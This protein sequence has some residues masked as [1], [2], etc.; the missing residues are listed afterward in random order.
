MERI[1]LSHLLLLIVCTVISTTVSAQIS[2]RQNINL[3]EGWTIRPAYDVNRQ[4]PK[5]KITLPHIWNTSDGFDKINYSRESMIY[6]RRLNWFEDMTQKRLFL[7][8]DGVNSTCTVLVNGKV[9]GKHVGGYTAFCFEITDYVEEGEDALI[10]VYVSNV[11][12]LDVIPLSG[13]FNIYGGI[14]RPVHLLVTEKNCISPLDYA[15][16]GVYVKPVKVS[17][18]KA[19]FYVE[20]V[21]S[22]TEEKH[23]LKLG[24]TLIDHNQKEVESKI[25]EIKDNGS[26][27]VSQLLEIKNPI[28]WNGK[29]NPYCYQLKVALLK[30]N[31]I[32]DEVTETTG[33]RYFS[34]DPENGFSL[35]GKYLDLYGF[36]IHQDIAERGSAYLPCD[37][38]NSMELVKESGATVLRLTHY[39]HG[40]MMYDLADKN[41]IVLWTEIPF[42]GPG[43]YTGP[44]YVKDE[45]LES[46]TKQMLIEMI[47]QN[48]NHPSVFFWGL[49]NELK[50]DYDDPV[51]FLKELNAFVKKEDP[52]RLSTSTTFGSGNEFIG[53]TDL[54]GWNQYSGWYSGEPEQ[55]GVFMDKMKEKAKGVPVCVSE[56]GAGGSIITHQLPVKQP[57]PESNFHPE[58]WQILCHE[59]NWKALSTR[60]YIWGKF[61]WNFADFSS[62]IRNE[63]DRQG[64]N[65]KGLVTYDHKTKKDAFYFY[66]AN[67][68]PEPMIHIT[69]K[70]YI[71]RNKKTT[72]IKVFANIKNVELWINDIKIDEQTPN[73]LNTVV[74][75]DVQLNKG[76]NRIE[77]KTNSANK[78]LKDSCT[79][80]FTKT[81]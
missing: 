2:A 43:G 45:N 58:E 53:I 65:D 40:K 69:S 47:R 3:N 55:V 24:I 28:L 18:K 14:H 61:V 1:K 37:Y 9:A 11:Y 71:Y 34:V 17:E 22:L 64:I 66:K 13:D 77:V 19:S 67:W 74:W 70:R 4:A 8:F 25:I 50:L 16:S 10:T 59:G 33:F 52:S 41:G 48:Y 5:T 81:N 62:S 23:D 60:K 20:T 73:T 79:W 30:G 26:D 49:F 44:G 39:P 21:L 7:Y 56:Y 38:I 80:I 46:N 31:E 27:R 78:N 68:N 6:E 29:A 32:I 76:E 57:I 36:G 75:E 63:G 15:S 72:D 12:R 42:V 51:P 54:I 35:N